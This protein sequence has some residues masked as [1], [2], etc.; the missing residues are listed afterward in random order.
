[1]GERS[2]NY[3]SP[4]ARLIPSTTDTEKIKRDGYHLDSILVVTLDDDR[5]D[6]TDRQELQRIGD[7]LYGRKKGEH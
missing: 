7:K 1:M 4:L 6:W 2:V 3:R 5:L